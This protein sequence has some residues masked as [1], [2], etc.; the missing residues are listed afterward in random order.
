MRMF[1]EMVLWLG[2]EALLQTDKYRIDFTWKTLL[3]SAGPK[4]HASRRP[5][6]TYLFHKIVLKPKKN[7]RICR[8][9]FKRSSKIF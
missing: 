5:G 8:T 3:R 2:P 6:S 7:L 9:R 1:G 4:G